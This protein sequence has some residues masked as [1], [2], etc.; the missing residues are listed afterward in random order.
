MLCGNFRRFI[1]IGATLALL[2]SCDFSSPSSV[3]QEPIR[4]PQ[5]S[6]NEILEQTESEAREAILSVYSLN[7]MARAFDSKT[8][9]T[10]TGLETASVSD[11]SIGR[12]IRAKSLIS[13]SQVSLD[14]TKQVLTE[15]INV[16]LAVGKVDTAPFSDEEFIQ[17]VTERQLAS[18]KIGLGDVYFFPVYIAKQLVG[19]LQTSVLTAKSYGIGVSLISSDRKEKLVF[20]DEQE[21]RTFSTASGSGVGEFVVLPTLGVFWRFGSELIDAVSGKV[22]AVVGDA[23]NQITLDGERISVNISFDHKEQVFMLPIHLEV[24]P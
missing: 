24:Q 11:I 1:I 10:L 20:M 15:K 21:A 13:P 4:G 23:G 6:D 2:A 16:D 9:T 12:A 7:H 22:N 17:F 14:S 19:Y 3:T 18:I 8:L 5:L